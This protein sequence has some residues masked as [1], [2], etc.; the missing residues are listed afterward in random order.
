M[1]STLVRAACDHRTIRV[2]LRHWF[3]KGY[4]LLAVSDT[5]TFNSKVFTIEQVVKSLENGVTMHLY[6]EKDRCSVTVSRNTDGSAV[7][8]YE[9]L[10]FGY[11]A[12]SHTT[13][14][15]LSKVRPSRVSSGISAY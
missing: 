2:R 15:P 5:T 13:V 12:K 11:E 6:H 7:D 3:S 9:S 10:K 1:Q 4:R 8:G 14:K